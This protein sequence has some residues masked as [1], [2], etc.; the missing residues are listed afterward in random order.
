MI[1]NLKCTKDSTR[2]LKYDTLNIIA[3]YKVAFLYTSIKH[4]KKRIRAMAFTI[5]SIKTGKQ[6]KTKN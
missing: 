6:N 1:L 4:T 2:K 3:G 5:I